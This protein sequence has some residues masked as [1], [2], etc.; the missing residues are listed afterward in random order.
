MSVPNLVSDRAPLVSLLLIL[1]NVFLGFVVVGPVLGLGIA[2]LFYD[3]N[4]LNDI[5]TLD[6]RPGILV[7]LLVTQSVATFIGLI[8]FPILHIV[9]IE[10]KRIPPFFPPQQKPLFALFLVMAI[11]LTFMIAISPLVEWNMNIKFPEFL[12]GFE[13]WARDAED[14]TAQLTKVMTSFD[15]T[16]DLIIGV[17]V[18]A[19]LPAIG[20]ELVF[21]GMF[22]NEFFRGTGNIHLSIWVSAIIFSAIHFQFYGFL[23][24]L[25]LG[26]LFGYLYYWSGT[27]LIPMF[28]HFVNNAFGVI[29]IYLYRHEIT[30]L[31]VEDNTAAPLQYVI[32]NVVITAGLLYYIWRFYQQPRQTSDP[33]Y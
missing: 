16:G 30:E 21:R 11:G 28:A 12:K 22:Q 15:S 20:E 33:S 24:R 2:S 17:I 6:N 4:L 3:G 19:L 5:Q 18:I 10:H 25:L 8:I 13:R 29:M 9:A 31:N 14:K 7:P 1:L 32:L 26:A 23:P 27:L